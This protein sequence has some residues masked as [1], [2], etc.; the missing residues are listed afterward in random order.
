MATAC[1][2]LHDAV[3]AVLPATTAMGLSAGVI[4]T[5]APVAAF[6]SM[7]RKLPVL[8]GLVSEKPTVTDDFW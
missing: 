4:A 8:T 6:L 1:V 5:Q 7:M 2:T 3:Y